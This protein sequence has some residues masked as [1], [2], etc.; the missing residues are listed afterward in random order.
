MGS[1]PYWY[2]VPYKPDIDA[3]LQEL[4]QREF[5]AGRYYP[6]IKQIWALFPIG[7][8]S[9]SPGAQHRSIKEAL[10][11]AAE[12]GTGTIQDL[13]HVSDVPE[14][15]GAVT[16]LGDERIRSLYGTTKPTREMVEDNMD[17]FEDLDRGQ[18]T[19]IVVY[20]NGHPDEI[21]F[22]GMSVD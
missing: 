22:A 4:R 12:S 18:G 15:L 20:K 10:R 6:A 7:P 14:F 17:F 13:D 1:D 5:R 19:Y 2:F 9:P 3:A 16:R 8:D 21:L 11:D